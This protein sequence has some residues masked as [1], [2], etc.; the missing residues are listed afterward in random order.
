MATISNHTLLLLLLL[1]NDCFSMGCVGSGVSSVSP[2]AECLAPSY[3]KSFVGWAFPAPCSGAEE[4][5]VS[6]SS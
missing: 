3:M 5:R 1:G 4:L 2:S 6:M